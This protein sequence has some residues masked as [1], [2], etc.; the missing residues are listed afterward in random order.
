MLP[1][2]FAQQ[3]TPPYDPPAGVVNF[4]LRCRILPRRDPASA[5]VPTHIAPILPIPITNARRILQKAWLFNRIF[6]PEVKETGRDMRTE[7]KETSRGGLAVNGAG[8]WVLRPGVLGCVSPNRNATRGERKTV[9]PGGSA[10]RVLYPGM[11]KPL[12]NLAAWKDGAP[13][14]IN[15]E[16]ENATPARPYANTPVTAFPTPSFVA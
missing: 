4:R 11:M 8:C 12:L 10:T 7:Y 16:C 13:Q 1:L 6:K 3:E 5:V 2:L 9:L 14:W 15:P